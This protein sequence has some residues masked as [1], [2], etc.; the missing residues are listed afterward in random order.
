MFSIR[1]F[2]YPPEAY[3]IAVLAII[4]TVLMLVQIIGRYFFGNAI[5]WSEEIVRYLFLWII[6]L[7]ASYATREK[8]NITIDLLSKSLKGKQK[9]IIDTIVTVLWLVVCIYICI[10]SFDYTMFMKESG[11]TSTVLRIPLWLVY[12]AIPTGFSLMGIRVILNYVIDIRT[13][14]FLK[15]KGRSELGEDEAGGEK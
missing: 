13:G 6:M 4:V 9:F 2:K 8:A 15:N 1:K 10:I 12:L 7:G 14:T 5:S 3:T 11:A